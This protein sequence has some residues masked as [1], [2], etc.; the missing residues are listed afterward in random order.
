MCSSDGSIVGRFSPC[1]GSCSLGENRCTNTESP[2]T[3]CVKEEMSEGYHGRSQKVPLNYSGMSGED[4]TDLE[5]LR[6]D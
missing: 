2:N 5:N 4:F 6:R 3:R 1:P